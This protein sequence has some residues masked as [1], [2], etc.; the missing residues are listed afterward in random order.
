MNVD[1]PY[2]FVPEIAGARLKLAVESIGTNYEIIALEC[3]QISRRTLIN[4]FSGKGFDL[5][6]AN[7]CAKGLGID[8][9][10]FLLSPSIFFESEFISEVQCA[11]VSNLKPNIGASNRFE[12][13]GSD[14]HCI[15]LFCDYIT[16]LDIEKFANVRING[17][18]KNGLEC[19]FEGILVSYTFDR[20]IRAISIKSS[21]GLVMSVGGCNSTAEDIAAMSITFEFDNGSA[22]LLLNSPWGGYCAA[23]KSTLTVDVIEQLTSIGQVDLALTL[24]KRKPSVNSLVVLN[25]LRKN[26]T[27]LDSQS[28]IYGAYRAFDKVLKKPSGLSQKIAEQLFYEVDMLLEE[29]DVL[30]AIYCMESLGY[31]CHSE[32][33][34][35]QFNALARKVIDNG[36]RHYDPHFIWA[37]N[38]ALSSVLKQSYDNATH[39][40][41]MDYIVDHN[42]IDIV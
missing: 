25:K 22:A 3:F 1:K 5:Y 21:T 6:K 42:I 16:K 28:L 35:K 8:V 7:K 14:T 33:V 41:F 40:Y 23:F 10:W 36:I 24:L 12:F 9:H 34:E 37:L 38:V 27:T 4:W 13:C 19:L 15:V 17:R 26:A 11:Y 31:F 32:A 29:G 39:E 2:T 18:L 30:A 20:Y